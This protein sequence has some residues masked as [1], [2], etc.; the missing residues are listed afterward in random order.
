MNSAIS[1]N[2]PPIPSLVASVPVRV[3]PGVLAVLTNSG[4]ENSPVNEALL[5]KERPGHNV[6]VY[7]GTK[8]LDILGEQY[9]RF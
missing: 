7:Y 3:T 4:A 6:S 2:M 5:V 8:H 1:P 9:W